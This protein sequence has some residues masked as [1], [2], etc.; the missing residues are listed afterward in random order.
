[1]LVRAFLLLGLISLGGCA[2][3]RTMVLESEPTGALVFLNGEEVARTPAEIPLEW[4]GKYDVTVRKEGYETL[5]EQRWVTA[6]WWQWV[7]I[8]LVAELLPVPLH[9]RRRLDFKLESAKPGDDFVLERAELERDSHQQ[10]MPATQPTSQ[11]ATQPTSQTA[12]QPSQLSQ[13]VQP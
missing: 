1:M 4:Y 3:K 13:P 7:P 2:V 9:D 6:P 5:K 8:D 10:G 11:P 12:S